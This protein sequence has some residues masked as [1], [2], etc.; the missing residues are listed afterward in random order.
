MIF[1][2]FG[3]PNEPLEA[4][5]APFKDWEEIGGNLFGDGGDLLGDG[6]EFFFAFSRHLEW[7]GPSRNG[8]IMSGIKF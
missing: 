5:L 4:E 8:P 2:F 1:L 3:S 6:G 7:G